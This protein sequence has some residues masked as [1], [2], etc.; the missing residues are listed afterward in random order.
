VSE[1][2]PVYLAGHS[3]GGAAV[4]AAAQRVRR[5]IAAMFLFDAVD[6]T[7]DLDCATISGNVQNVYHAMRNPEFAKRFETERDKALLETAKNL[8]LPTTLGGF[9]TLISALKLSHVA[10]QDFKQKVLRFRT[11]FGNAGTSVQPPGRYFREKFMCT[12]GAVGGV[13]WPDVPGD[14]DES[15][16]V[17]TWMAARMQGE[18]IY[19]IHGV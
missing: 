14:A 3:R 16:E 10:A 8:V 9:P 17:W 13:P 2:E 12:H 1:A 4:I 18:G 11:V 5:K 7:V 15:K 19:Q 6:R